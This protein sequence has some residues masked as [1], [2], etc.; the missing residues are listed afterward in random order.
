VLRA[1]EAAPRRQRRDGH[2]VQFQ[3]LVA[4]GGGDDVDNGI[5]RAD[6][7]EV[8]LFGGRTMDFRFG[9]GQRRENR[10]RAILNA[11]GKRRGTP[12]DLANLV[13]MAFGLPRGH[14][15]LELQRRD[16]AYQLAPRG[17]AIAVERQRGERRAQLIEVRARIE[18]R[19]R[20]H[21]AA[22]PENASRKADFI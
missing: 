8:D 19:A 17:H 3:P 9:L 18:H 15:D 13:E 14:L 22:D 20:D 21:V 1:D 6:L 12:D 7:V 11:G 2:F 4:P 10:H 16:A 5:D